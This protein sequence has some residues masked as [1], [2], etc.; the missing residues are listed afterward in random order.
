MRGLA[1]FKR[2]LCSANVQWLPCRPP[3]AAL[4]SSFKHPALLPPGAIRRSARAI[5]RG[6][7]SGLHHH[8]AGVACCAGP[9]GEQPRE[10]K[11][12]GAARKFN[13]GRKGRAKISRTVDLLDHW[14]A[15]S[16]CNAAD[17]TLLLDT[18][19]RYSGNPAT[20]KEYSLPT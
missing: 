1:V 2:Q 18:F 15:E 14:Q 16:C 3:A 20:S 5:R 12:E 11:L 8:T 6:A 10:L 17:D 9:S 7:R 19:E 13:L 4:G